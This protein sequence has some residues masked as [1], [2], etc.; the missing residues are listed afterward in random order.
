MTGSQGEQGAVLWRVANREHRSIRL[1]PSDTVIFSSRVIPGNE[2][3]VEKLKTALIDGGA[4]IISWK[5]APNIHVAVHAAAAEIKRMYDIL[6]PKTVIPVMGEPQHLRA[7]AEV[8][9]Q[10]GV[11]SVLI[12]Q[13]GDV[14]KLGAGKAPQK[15]ETVETGIIALDG[16]RLIV[17][18]EDS[19]LFRERR[20][21]SYNGVCF[22][23]VA[24]DSGLRLLGRPDISFV[25]LADEG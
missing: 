25:G 13:N 10:C 8:A 23:T 4:K 17:S 14:I 12:V 22:I 18:A 24:F 19:A 2:D 9:K 20:K 6:K 1:R 7:H 11:D 5:D 21:A 3:K 16:N 15:V